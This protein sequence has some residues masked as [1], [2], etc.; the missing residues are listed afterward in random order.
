MNSD[1]PKNSAEEIEARIT[2][3]LLGEL[4]E[5]EAAAVRNAMA[6][7]PNLAR[8]HEQLSRAIGLVRDAASGTEPAVVPSAKPLQFP[9]G[10]RELLLRTFQIEPFPKGRKEL[11]WM[12]PVSIAAVLVAMA[13]SVALLPEFVGVSGREWL[14]FSSAKSK[15]YHFQ[16]RIEGNGRGLSRQYFAKAD[17]A[18]PSPNEPPAP[19]LPSGPAPAPKAAFGEI[20]SRGVKLPL[21]Q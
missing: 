9:A 2:A 19:P 1:S 3:L 18:L 15:G 12:I 11:H 6:Q 8:L 16:D 4:S 7:D 14:A 5:A 10:R 17:A 21:Q 13:G 20:C